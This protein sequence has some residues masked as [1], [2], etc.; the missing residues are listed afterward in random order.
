MPSTFGD[1]LRLFALSVDVISQARFDRVARLIDDYCNETLAIDTTR[2]YLASDIDGNPGLRRYKLG[3]LDAI[4]SCRYAI[5]YFSQRG[6][7][8]NYHDNPNV[9]FEAGMFHGRV[10]EITTVPSSWIPIREKQSADLPIDFA[11]ERILIPERTRSG[12]LKTAVFAN[13]LRQQLESMLVH[14]ESTR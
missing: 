13:L 6:E 10:D 8:G 5:C 12:A 14:Q 7:D 3:V 2:L 11:Q 4:A 9:V 1:Q